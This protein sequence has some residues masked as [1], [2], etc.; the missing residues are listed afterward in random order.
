[1]TERTSYHRLFYI[2]CQWFCLLASS[3]GDPLLAGVPDAL[4]E[5]AILS[6]GATEIDFKVHIRS[7]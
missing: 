3:P 4:L 5:K 2:T 1:M 6:T 7:L